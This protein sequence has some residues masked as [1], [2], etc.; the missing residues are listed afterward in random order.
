MFNNNEW[1]TI[2]EAKK[3]TMEAIKKEYDGDLF[4]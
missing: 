4:R 2:D 3:E 1:L